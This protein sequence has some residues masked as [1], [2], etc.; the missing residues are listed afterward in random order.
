LCRTPSVI[1]E[2]NVH[3]SFSHLIDFLAWCIIFC[4]IFA[5]KNQ[6]G[7]LLNGENLPFFA[8]ALAPAS[9]S[10]VIM[11]HRRSCCDFDM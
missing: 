8:R 3:S 5:S 11:A 4:R 6:L 7:L 1:S 2:A 10:L 9:S